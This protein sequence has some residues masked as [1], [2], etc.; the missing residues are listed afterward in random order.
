MRNNTIRQMRAD[1]REHLADRW[2]ELS[3][4]ERAEYISRVRDWSELHHDTFKFNSDDFITGTWHATQ[5]LGEYVFQTIEHIK[6]Y[7]SDY[8]GEVTTDFSNPEQVVNRYAYIEGEQAVYELAER[9]RL[10]VAE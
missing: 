5:W 1:V 6:E 10:E 9:Y 2:D 7:E 4:Y 8:F 3:I